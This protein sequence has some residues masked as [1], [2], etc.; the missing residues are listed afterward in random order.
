MGLGTWLASLLACVV[1][2]AAQSAL[3]EQRLSS[4]ISN[5]YYDPQL[6]A[7]GSRV[8]GAWG[9]IDVSP[10]AVSYGYSLDRGLTWTNEAT[11][12]LIFSAFGANL[13]FA[14]HESGDGS[15]HL[16]TQNYSSV[17]Y[18]RPD[19]ATPL[20]TEAVIAEASDGK[21]NDL[22]SIASDPSVGAVYF[23][24]THQSDDYI[25]PIRFIRSLDNGLTWSPPVVLSSANCNGSSMVVAPDGTLYMTWVDYAL[26]QVLL[27]RST[28]HGATFSPTIA[29]ANM[30]DNLNATPVGWRDPPGAYSPRAY[31]HFRAGVRMHAAP[32][33]PALAVDRSNSPSRGTLYLTWA[34]HAEGA[35]AAA[36]ASFSDIELNDTPETAQPVTLDCNISGSLWTGGHTG[37]V[38]SDWFAFD[39]VAGQTLQL[40]GANFG[41][42]THDCTLYEQLPGAG[43]L[44]I[45]VLPMVG[46]ADQALGSRQ[47]PPIVTLPRTGR[48]LLALHAVTVEGWSYQVRLRTLDISPTSL[49]RD[50]RDIVLIRSTDGGVTWSPKVRVNHDV[51]GADQHQPNVAVDEQGRVY[52]AWYD[53]RGSEFGDQVHAYASVSSDC[54]ATFSPDLRLSASP[55]NWAGPNLVGSSTYPGDLVGDRIAVAAGDQFGMVAWADAREVGELTLGMSIYAAR[56]VDVPTA[57]TAVT[58]LAAER[59]AGAVRLRW[60][61]ND[62]RGLAAIDVLRSEGGGA[63]TVIGSAALTGAEGEA[64]YVDASVELGRTYAYRLRVTGSGGTQHLGPVAVTISAPIPAL[65]W[66]AAGP[67]P[68]GERAG[69]TLAV[70]RAGAGVVRVYDVQGKLVRTL[71]EGPLE[72]GERQ[73]EWDGRDVGGAAVA[74]GLYFVAAQAGGETVHTRLTRVR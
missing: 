27:R 47:K 21:P 6:R 32:N 38:D 67:N 31:P 66:R 3:P 33:F 53:R 25:Y 36:T 74:P 13:P 59:L 17:Y 58:D 16:M 44:P 40:D 62:A 18:R 37:P 49:A 19:L 28:D 14:L 54:G 43:R 29:V 24:Y 2:A 11:L 50:M 63:E 30:L 5:V 71:H 69:M 12:P 51:A 70:P 45:A 48:Y 68:F 8:F 52:V 9:G 4:A 64:E 39:G 60:R 10:T 22:R 1:P 41:Y 23:A 55:T 57:V 15:V 46:S 72:P 7:S 35:P 42:Y 20:W 65:A 61:V 26:G 56:I 73:L 34:E